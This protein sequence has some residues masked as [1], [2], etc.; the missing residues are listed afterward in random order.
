MLT[1]LGAETGAHLGH[2]GTCVIQQFSQRSAGHTC[3]PV[4]RLSRFCHGNTETPVPQ[5]F[6]VGPSLLMEMTYQKSKLHGGLIHSAPK[7]PSSFLLDAVER[8]VSSV[9]GPTPQL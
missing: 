4:L 9:Q 3:M 5:S 1:G 7:E 6:P 2:N 8:R